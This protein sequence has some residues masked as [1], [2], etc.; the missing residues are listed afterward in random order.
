VAGEHDHT[1][2]SYRYELLT[3][4]KTANCGSPGTGA[5]E[6]ARLILR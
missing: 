6:S 2:R 3:L 5:W 4:P 1:A